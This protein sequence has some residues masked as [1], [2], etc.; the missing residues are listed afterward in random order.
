M[1][2]AEQG[3]AQVITVEVKMTDWH[4]YNE[5][6][7]EARDLNTALFLVAHDGQLD[8]RKDHLNLEGQALLGYV[9]TSYKGAPAPDS[10]PHEAYM[11]YNTNDL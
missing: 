1:A 7:R 8:V 3:N 5:L 2:A 6:A 10:Q 9:E 11:I 4:Q